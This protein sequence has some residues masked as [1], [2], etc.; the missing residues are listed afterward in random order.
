MLGPSRRPSWR[1][2]GLSWGRLGGILEVILA[3]WE[4]IGANGD[5]NIRAFFVA[6]GLGQDPRGSSSEKKQRHTVHP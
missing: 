1:H 6:S 4:P 3:V 2:R 5:R